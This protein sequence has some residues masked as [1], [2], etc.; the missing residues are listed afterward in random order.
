MLNYLEVLKHEFDAEEGS[1]LYKL[2]IEFVWDKES[3]SRL[4]EAMRQCCQDTGRQQTLDRWMAL[5]FWFTYSFVTG[6]VNHPNFPKQF[7]E[8][9]Y[10]QSFNILHSLTDRSFVGNENLESNI[11]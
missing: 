9:Y 8:E 7:P 11:I 3:F 6:W 10:T 5:G 1:F 4:T 2:R